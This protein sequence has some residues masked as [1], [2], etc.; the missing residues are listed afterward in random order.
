MRKA[1]QKSWFNGLLS[2][3]FALLLFFNAN[4][5]GN[6]PSNSGSS[7]TYSE[8]LNNIP[9]QVQYDKD[10]YYVSGFE[11]SVNVHL[12]S[13]NRIQLN[14]ESNADTRNFPSGRRLN[15]IAIR[16]FGST[17]DSAGTKFSCY[18]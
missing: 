13:A 8:T 10:K 17:L 2:L 14:M 5:T 12:R 3:L 1:S 4:A 6:N 9:V 18:S 15:Q 7:Q 11:E 16:D